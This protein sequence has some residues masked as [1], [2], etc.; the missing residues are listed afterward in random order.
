MWEIQVSGCQLPAWLVVNARMIPGQVKP[1][2]TQ[3]LSKT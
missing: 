1:F 3:A 2:F